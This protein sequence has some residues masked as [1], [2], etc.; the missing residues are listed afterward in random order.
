MSLP[1]A[2]ISGVSQLLQTVAPAAAQVGKPGEFASVLNGAIQGVENYRKQAD[3]AVQ[4]LVNGGN[5]EL[6]TTALAVQRAELSFDLGLQIRNKIV[7]AYQEV[8]RMQL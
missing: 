8:M 4:S 5:E 3:Q 6:H 7:E 1:I 2:P